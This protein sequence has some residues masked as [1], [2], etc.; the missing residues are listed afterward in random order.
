MRNQRVLSLGLNIVSS[1]F[2]RFIFET[3][4]FDLQFCVEDYYFLNPIFE[5]QFLI[6][7]ITF[8]GKIKSN[9]SNEMKVDPSKRSTGGDSEYKFLFENHE[10]LCHFYIVI[11]TSK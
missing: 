9:A 11:K 5:G 6:L 8:K 4:R 1:N 10:R 3:T 2:S 7:S